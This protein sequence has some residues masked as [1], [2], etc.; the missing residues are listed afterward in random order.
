MK[1]SKCGHTQECHNGS[2]DNCLADDWPCNEFVASD[3][4]ENPSTAH[5]LFGTSAIII[6]GPNGQTATY[7]CKKCGALVIA[8]S[9]PTHEHWHED[10]DN[11]ALQ[12]RGPN[13]VATAQAIDEDLEIDRAFRA[14]LTEARLPQSEVLHVGRLVADVPEGLVDRIVAGLKE[15]LAEDRH[16]REE[17]ARQAGVTVHER[18]TKAHW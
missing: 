4:P 3:F 13:A 7:P 17:A 1:C 5:P 12:A 2:G 10:L 18:P 9:T 6:M 15:A 16:N 11:I 8:S 14:R